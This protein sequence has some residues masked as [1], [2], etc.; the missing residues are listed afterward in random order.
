MYPW[1]QRDR[2][3]AV[4]PPS[5]L[6]RHLVGDFAPRVAGLW[7][8]PHAPF[9]T[10]PPERRHLV[11]IAL[12]RAGGRPLAF[13]AAALLE[14]PLNEATALVVADPPA[15]LRR[16]LQRLGEEAWCGL[17]YEALLALL[18]C[19]V[20]AKTLRHAQTIRPATMEALAALPQS[21]VRAGVGTRFALTADQARLLAE[22]WDAVLLRR[23][24]E[25]A[26]HEALRWGQCGSAKALFDNARD[27]MHPEFPEP[28]FSGS[29]RLA[30]L[31]TK[32]ALREAAI[33]YRNCLRW[34]MANASRGQAAYYEW[35]G[36]PGVVVEIWRDDTFGWRLD[37][38]KLAD[39][40]SPPAAVREAINAELRSWGVHVGRSGRQ[41]I[42]DLE[43]ACDVGFEQGS[44]EA[45]IAACYE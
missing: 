9:L 5:S 25:D 14:A 7:P 23:T 19:P 6:L 10:A 32:A 39:N 4:G 31:A 2:P 29:A 21:L 15:G 45:A 24:P 17:H 36:P 13:D 27:S 40:E 28:P 20:R 42:S 11:C 41:I 34:R 37:E 30:P 44:I 26:A 12:G 16:A 38:A 18:A 3:V 8:Q 43:D 22:T 1:I 35:K 33:R